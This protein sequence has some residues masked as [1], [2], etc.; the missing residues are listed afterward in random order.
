[1][2]L[3]FTD[4]TLRRSSNHVSGISQIHRD[5][6]KNEKFK[7]MPDQCGFFFTLKTSCIRNLFTR[8]GREWK[9]L[10]WLAEVAEGQHPVQTFSEV[11]QQFLGL[12]HDNTPAYTPLPWQRASLHTPSRSTVSYFSENDSYSA[13]SLLTRPRPLWLFLFLKMRLKLK[14]LCFESIEEIQVESQDVMSWCKITFTG[15]SHG[16]PGGIAVLTHKGS[17]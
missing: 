12:H 9:I 13:P 16:S 11:V 5:P 17:I 2:N 7:T 6:R 10:L 4:M 3:E 1:M 14:E 15:D 8:T